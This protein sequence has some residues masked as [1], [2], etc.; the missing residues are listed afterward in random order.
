M[1]MISVEELPFFSNSDSQSSSRRHIPRFRLDDGRL[2]D[3]T[4]RQIFRHTSTIGTLAVDQLID[5]PEITSALTG[6]L[7]LHRVSHDHYRTVMRQRLRHDAEHGTEANVD[8]ELQTDIEALYGIIGSSL[9]RLLSTRTAT[10]M[11]PRTHSQKELTG[12]ITEETIMAIAAR[13]LS[14]STD[15]PYLFIPTSSAADHLG[16]GGDGY[17]HGFDFHV[18][19]RGGEPTK[20]QV[21]TSFHQARDNHYAPDISVISLDQIVGHDR[22]QVWNLPEAIA[23]EVDGNSTNEDTLVINSATRRF[24]QLIIDQQ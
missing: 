11:S 12:A 14:G 1:A 21:K 18:V 2:I 24:N 15:D 23:R 4:N 16:Y 6:A 17:N 13:Q 3:E 19:R 8:S 20:L 7:H 9:G 10:A 22:K 5:T